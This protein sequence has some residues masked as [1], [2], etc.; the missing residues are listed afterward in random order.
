M[1]DI[2]EDMPEKIDPKEAMR[3]ELARIDDKIKQT[4]LKE[5]RAMKEIASRAIT[6]TWR[7]F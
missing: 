7:E 2:Y 3:E 4:N 6:L 1:N 5:Q